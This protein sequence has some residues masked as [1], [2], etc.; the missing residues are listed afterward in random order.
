MV[1]HTIRIVEGE[2]L[3]V[4]WIRLKRIPEVFP[5]EFEQESL[6]MRY[7]APPEATWEARRLTRPIEKGEEEAEAP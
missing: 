3:D 1:V 7:T 6:V 4:E 2:A 5:P